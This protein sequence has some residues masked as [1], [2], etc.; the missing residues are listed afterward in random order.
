MEIA[1]LTL[2][3]EVAKGGGMNLRLET[4]HNYSCPGWLQIFQTGLKEAGESLERQQKL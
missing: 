2:C 3:Y 4:F 1:A